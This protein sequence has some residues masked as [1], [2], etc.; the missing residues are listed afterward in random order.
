M[1]LLLTK[2]KIERGV[3][4][5]KLWLVRNPTNNQKVNRPRFSH[6]SKY[7]LTSKVRHDLTSA[8]QN[9]GSGCK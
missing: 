5:S 6:Q 4:D 8:T 2:P 9:C 1:A 7:E 3:R